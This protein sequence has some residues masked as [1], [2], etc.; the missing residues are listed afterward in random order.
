MT[1]LGFQ[2][3]PLI[4]TQMTETEIEIAAGKLHVN[5]LGAD[6]FAVFFS[7]GGDVDLFREQS[8][9]EHSSPIRL[10][11]CDRFIHYQ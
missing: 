4:Q 8:G 3:E 2:K 10:P 5:N 7:Y 1:P 9:Y 6:G 11:D